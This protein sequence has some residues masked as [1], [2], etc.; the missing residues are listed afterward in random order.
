VTGL[1][2][3]SVGSLAY[4]V[5]STG[6]TA[7]TF[8]TE[9]N[10]NGGI[11]NVDLDNDG[12]VDFLSVSE[13]VGVN[14]SR[15]FIITDYLNAGPTKIATITADRVA[16]K[17]SIAV[18]GNSDIYGQQAQ[19]SFNF[20]VADAALFAYL[21]GASH[22]VYI[23]PYTR[24]GYYPTYYGTGYREIEPVQ[25]VKRVE[26]VKT[27]RKVPSGYS[28]TTDESYNKTS[29]KAKYESTPKAPERSYVNAEKSQRS[30][31]VRDD[32]KPVAT[33]GFGKP[34]TEPYKSETKKPETKSYGTSKSSG[35][36]TPTKSTP[37]KSY[38]T[39]SYE[40]SSSKSYGSSKSSGFGSGSKKKKY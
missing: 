1:N 31:E 29:T 34:K 26:T 11:N 27:V 4:D 30:F 36:G 6:G 23:S 18:S 5:F 32:K 2:L 13:S 12:I 8:Q 25:Y 19:H 16:N 9:L 22:Q 15:Q 21:W 10:K 14:Y 28:S 7:E 37:T 40:S 24:Y 38:E 17:G 39:K 35:F 20:D 3:Q 33:G